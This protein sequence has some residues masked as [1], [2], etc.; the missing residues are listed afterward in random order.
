MFIGD[1]EM[2]ARVE[3]L[4]IEKQI[5]N[6]IIIIIIINIGNRGALPRKQ[7]CTGS[8][9]IYTCI[10]LLRVKTSLFFRKKKLM[11]YHYFFRIK[12]DEKRCAWTAGAWIGGGGAHG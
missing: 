4:F 1:E 9:P 5:N 12:I 11:K 6:K 3:H 8:A 7:R 10:G 2:F